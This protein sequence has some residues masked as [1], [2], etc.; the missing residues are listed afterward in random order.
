MVFSDPFAS[1][2]AHEFFGFLEM[3]R[4][5]T[6][7]SPFL[8]LKDCDFPI[9]FRQQMSGGKPGETCP[10]DHAAFWIHISTISRTSMAYREHTTD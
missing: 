1:E 10:D 9:L 6:S 5:D 3:E 8:S 2:L 7:S 4:I